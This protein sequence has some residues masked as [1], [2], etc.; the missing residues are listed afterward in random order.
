V[1]TSSLAHSYQQVGICENVLSC[2]LTTSNKDDHDDGNL[3]PGLELWARVVV[4]LCCS[5]CNN[6]R[7]GTLR[8]IITMVVLC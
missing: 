6:L 8:A 3:H 2:I 1:P 7:W 5:N 4:V